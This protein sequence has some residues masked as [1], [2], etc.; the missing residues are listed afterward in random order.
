M[1]GKVMTATLLVTLLS[2]TFA[3]TILAQDQ[4]ANPIECVRPI[5]KPIIKKAVF[6]NTKFVLKNTDGVPTGLETVK[7]NNGDELII[8]H[9]GCE[10]FT[11]G[12]Q[13]TTSRFQSSP[14][15]TKYLF[16]RSM[17][18]MRQ[19]EPGLETETDIKRGIKALETYGRTNRHPLIGKE[20]DYGG[21]EIRSIA[22]VASVKQIG[23]KKLVVIL[24]FS[25]GP[26]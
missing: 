7:F 26:L 8:T 13:F 24:N 20:I 25:V 18:L 5:P 22:E 14:N 4:P 12:F 2:T 6:P 23:R 9:T 15:N 1:L 17:Q 10:N 3:R 21:Q 19:T 11:L 16:T